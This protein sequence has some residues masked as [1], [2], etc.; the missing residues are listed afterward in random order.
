M[1]TLPAPPGDAAMT[2]S[3]AQITTQVTLPEKKLYAVALGMYDTQSEARP[4]AAEYAQRGAAGVIVETGEGWALLGAGYDSEAEAGSVCAQLRANEDIS[5]Q[6]IMFGADE[7]QISLT[8]SRVQAEAIIAAL[9]ILGSMPAELMQLASQL[10]RSEINAATA[11]TL[12]AVALAESACTRD[13]LISALGTTAD[14]FSRLTE[15][16]IM[17]LCCM[18]ETAADGDGMRGLGLSS[19]LKQCALETELGI[20]GLMNTVS[21]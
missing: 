2:S 5:A 19:W 17:E 10:D 1:Y 15:T 9:D 4:Y 20:I 3:G 16:E 14:I 18:L 11:R 7:V 8:A 13:A 6:V 21:R 12:T